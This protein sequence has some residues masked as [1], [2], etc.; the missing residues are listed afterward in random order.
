VAALVRKQEEMWL[1]DMGMKWY[2]HVKNNSGKKLNSRG[3]FKIPDLVVLE[4]ALI[5]LFE[6]ASHRCAA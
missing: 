3:G 6:V 1:R 4:T 2:E 5:W